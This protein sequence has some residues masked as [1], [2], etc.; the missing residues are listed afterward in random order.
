MNFIKSCS[1]RRLLYLCDLVA[2]SQSPKDLGVSMKLINRKLSGQDRTWAQG[3]LT[4]Q[5][6][7]KA[8]LRCLSDILSPAISWDVGSSFGSMPLLLSISVRQYTAFPWFLLSRDPAVFLIKGNIPR[9]QRAGDHKHWIAMHGNVKITAS[10]L[11]IRYCAVPIPAK[12]RA[13][14]LKMVKNRRYWMP[15]IKLHNS[16]RRRV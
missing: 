3:L 2:V 6:I 8:P 16:V 13:R 9:P 1:I 11:A 4:A 5:W 7:M 10:T 14:G 15:K 12:S